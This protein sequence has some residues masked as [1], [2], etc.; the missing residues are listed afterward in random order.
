[1]IFTMPLALASAREDAASEIVFVFVDCVRQD[2][3]VQFIS[4]FLR[5]HFLSMVGDSRSHSKIVRCVIWS[6]PNLPYPSGRLHRTA[7][8]ACA[9][10]V[11]CNFVCN[12][13]MVTNIQITLWCRVNCRLYCLIFGNDS[14]VC[15]EL[16]MKNPRRRRINKTVQRHIWSCHLHQ[17][18]SRVTTRSYPALPVLLFIFSYHGRNK[19]QD[20]LI[21]FSAFS[22]VSRTIGTS[23]SVRASTK[24]CVLFVCKFLFSTVWIGCSCGDVSFVGYLYTLREAKRERRRLWD[25]T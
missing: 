12:P 2:E 20:G 17:G 13:F 9:P 6:F 16:S 4:R 24:M 19:V 10:R 22:R 8:C 25:D 11:C 15:A 18:F 5:S 23:V 14:G 1:M 21:R 7:G 3:I